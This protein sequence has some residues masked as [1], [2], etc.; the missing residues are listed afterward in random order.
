MTAA[1]LTLTSDAET[2]LAITLAAFAEKD[3]KVSLGTVAT[4]TV[5]PSP[6]DKFANVSPRRIQLDENGNGTLSVYVGKGAASVDVTVTISA[7]IVDGLSASVPS[8]QTTVTVRT[9]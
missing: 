9:P 3:G 2:N 1:P 6:L 7:P 8:L 4:A 5:T